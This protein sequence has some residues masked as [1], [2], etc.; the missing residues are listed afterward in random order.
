[1]PFLRAG[2]S[3]GDAPLMNASIAGGV[4]YYVRQRGDLLGFGVSWGHP[5]TPGLGDQVSSEL[6]YRLQLSPNFAVTPDVQLLLNPATNPSDD[7]V[8]VLGVRGRLA[9]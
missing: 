6:F 4:G 8:W 9:F 1:M 5:A 3:D 2:W 7:V